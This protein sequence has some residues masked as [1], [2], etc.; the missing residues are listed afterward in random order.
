MKRVSKNRSGRHPSK[1]ANSKPAKLAYPSRSEEDEAL[2]REA[3]IGRFLVALSAH[4]LVFGPQAPQSFESML[5]DSLKDHGLDG[6]LF[7]L[8]PEGMHSRSP[9]DC[10]ATFGRLAQKIQF[11][12]T[13]YID[14]LTRTFIGE[15][16]HGIDTCAG[17]STERS[18]AK[19]DRHAAVDLSVILQRC[20]GELLEFPSRKAAA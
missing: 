1:P 18:P 9:I 7:R 19:P 16:A 6:G 13:G 4:A 20:F 15:V 8:S 11:I 12:S 10:Q 2:E 14:H 5:D 17:L 3:A